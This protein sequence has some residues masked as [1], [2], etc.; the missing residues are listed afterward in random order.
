MLETQ[1]STLVGGVST[2]GSVTLTRFAHS[3][4]TVTRT[5]LQSGMNDDDHNAPALMELPDG[6]IMAMWSGHGRHPLRYRITS[7]KDSLT[8]MSGATPLRGS[9]LEST[10]ASYAH[11]LRQDGHPR[12][13]IALT[14]RSSDDM[15]VMT[16]SAD[17]V[18]WTPAVQLLARVHEQDQHHPYLK[19][20]IHADAIHVLATDRHPFRGSTSLYHFV[21]RGERV[22][23][24]DG[25]LIMT[26]PELE[27]GRP[28]TVSEATLV[29]DGS[30]ADG[31]PRVY[32]IMVGAD[33]IPRIGVTTSASSTFTFKWGIPKEQGT[34]W[35]LRTLARQS[36]T[37]P[38]GMSLDSGDPTRVLLARM[39]D[40]P[41]LVEYRT[42]DEGDTW[43]ARV[44]TK[45]SGL[46]TPTTP[47]GSGGPMSALWMGGRYDR[48]DDYDTQVWGLTTGVAPVQLVSTWSRSWDDGGAVVVKLRA[49][50]SGPDVRDRLVRLM[51]RLPGGAEETVRTARTD[52]YGN[53]RLTVPDLPVGARARVMHAKSDGWGYATSSTRTADS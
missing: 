48:Y 6:R 16:R 29:Y 44:V 10:G 37:L 45:M 41:G 35:K 36:G 21:L 14:R 50:V 52:A 30:S 12:P 34:G 42:P 39:L 11:L 4:G 7:S 5:T 32:D 31:R 33:G 1:T 46:R 23:R 20:A 25:S 19:F 49:G 38:A 18:T 2:S 13:Y 9:G 40:K 15:W 43:T 51:V 47:Y 28:V 22:E 24:T 3:S 53:A 27:A 8:R 26:L 17:L